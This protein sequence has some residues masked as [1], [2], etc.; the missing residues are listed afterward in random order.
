MSHMQQSQLLAAHVAP[1]A[2]RTVEQLGVRQ[3]DP[4]SPFAA[5]PVRER[6]ATGSRIHNTHH[7]GLVQGTHHVRAALPSNALAPSHREQTGL[8]EVLIEPAN[9]FALTAQS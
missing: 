2:G 3:W 4:R 9:Q 7:V 8:S 5:W 6:A 1:A